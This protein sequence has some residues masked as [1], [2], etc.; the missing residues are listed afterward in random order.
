MKSAGE[1]LKKARL[2]KALSIAQVAKITKIRAEFLEKIEAADYQA[3]PGEAY[4]KGFLQT[5]A[6]AVG[7]ESEKVLAFFRREYEKTQSKTKRLTWQP[8]G[9]QALTFTPATLLATT[10]TILITGFLVFLAWQYKNFAGAPLLLVYEPLD[11]AVITRPFVNVVG[12]ADTSAHL[13]INGE[14]VFVGNEGSFQKTINLEKG[15]HL[16][17]IVAANKLGKSSEVTRTIEVNP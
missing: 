1:I 5:Y 14:E 7:L 16:L 10:V 12:K 2:E 4:I 9:T 17:K 11:Q 13:T 8:I 15:V 6:R 3:L